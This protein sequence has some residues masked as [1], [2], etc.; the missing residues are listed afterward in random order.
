M[1]LSSRGAMLL[2]SFRHVRPLPAPHQSDVDS[3]LNGWDRLP[4]QIPARDM[5]PFLQTNLTA[6]IWRRSRPWEQ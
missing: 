4:N 3:E 6:S 1:R 2:P 5:G